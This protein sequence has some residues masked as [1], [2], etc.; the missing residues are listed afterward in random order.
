MSDDAVTFISHHFALITDL[1]VL[2]VQ[3]VATAAAAK[4]I[5]FKPVRRVLFILCRHVVSLFALGALQNNIISRHNS[6]FR[7][8]ALTCLREAS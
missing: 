3:P 8:H 1:F 2:S 4:F 5:K 6:S 7:V